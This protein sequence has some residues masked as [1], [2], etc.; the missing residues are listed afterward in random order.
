MLLILSPIIIIIIIEIVI[1][2]IASP[3]HDLMLS[4]QAV[5]SMAFL[6]S[7]SSTISFFSGFLQ[8]GFKTVIASHRYMRSLPVFTDQS[9]QRHTAQVDRYAVMQ[10]VYYALRLKS[11][12]SYFVIHT[13][14]HTPVSYT[15]LTLPTIYSV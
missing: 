9:T 6:C 12:Y 4:S 10:R 7:S 8:N 5:H 15:H 3:A 1:I 13:H 14:T 2:I 11:V